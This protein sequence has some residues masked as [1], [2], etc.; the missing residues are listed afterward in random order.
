MKPLVRKDAFTQILSDIALV[1]EIT[2]TPPC[3]HAKPEYS[4]KLQ[5]EKHSNCRNQI[6]V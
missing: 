2:L 5:P 4:T 6:G 3:T 1:P